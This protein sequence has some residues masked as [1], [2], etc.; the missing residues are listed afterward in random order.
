MN[1]FA[2]RAAGA[3]ATRDSP[4]AVV[5]RH[6]QNLPVPLGGMTPV[7][8]AHRRRRRPIRTH[9]ARALLITG[10]IAALAGMALLSLP[11]TTE[12]YL[13]GD[14]I[15]VGGMTLTAAGPAGRGG[16]TL[17]AGD[18]SYVLVEPGDGSATASAVWSEQGV[19]MVARCALHHDGQRL[20]DECAFDGASGRLTSV[21]VL[22]PSAGS[23]W[24]RTYSDGVRVAIAVGQQGAAVPVPFPIGR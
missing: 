10:L 17:Y 12:A 3:T 5:D 9:A 2:A 18:A 6:P 23:T 19:A 24:Q 20:V 21:D 4:P 11:A 22:D 14:S 16:A 7:R 15:H 8:R 1:P 13:D